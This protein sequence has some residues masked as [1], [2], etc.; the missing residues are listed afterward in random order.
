LNQKDLSLLAYQTIENPQKRHDFL[1][2][3][4]E[5]MGATAAAV[6]VEDRQLRWSR[7]PLTHGMD[8]EAIDSYQGYYGGLNP[9]APRGV[10]A[11]G[12]VR[13]SDEVL[14]DAEFHETEFYQGWFK[15]RGWGYAAAVSLAATETERVT[16]FAMR[17]P[18]HPFT[19]KERDILKD[20]APH[21]ALATQITKRQT[22]LQ[23]T[24]NR[25]RSGAVKLDMLTRFK[26]TSTE[27][28]IALAL[29]D[30]KTPKEYAYNARI[31]ESTV[32]THVKTIYK[33]CG[34]NRQADLVRL[35]LDP[36]RQ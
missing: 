22:A 14:S 2:P 10:S 6:K 24:I 3:F 30:G 36:S 25:L 18:N 21:L 16:L 11:A 26:L 20:L 31:K 5:I 19:E 28:R 7:L 9:L 1:A 27:A 29:V 32:R 15:P 23:N 17:S 12:E 8:R 35:L 34:V 4:A 13:T 33:K